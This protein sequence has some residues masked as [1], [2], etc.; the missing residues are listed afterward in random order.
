MKK[1][2]YIIFG[3]LVLSIYGCSWDEGPADIIEYNQVD[4]GGSHFTRD[5]LTI[6]IRL[7]ELPYADEYIKISSDSFYC[8]DGNVLV[9]MNSHIYVYASNDYNIS[10]IGW[11]PD[12]IDN[13]AI[14]LVSGAQKHVYW[15]GSNCLVDSLNIWLTKKS[16]RN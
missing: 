8:S 1:L 3:W 11:L 9:Y 15:C 5:T 12:D 2:L 10:D 16:I 7:A 14:Q 13:K 4:K 6:G